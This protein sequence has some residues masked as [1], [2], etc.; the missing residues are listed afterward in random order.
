MDSLTILKLIVSLQCIRNGLAG[1]KF[2]VIE[3]FIY[4]ILKTVKSVKKFECTIQNL[5]NPLHCSI[6]FKSLQ[7]NR[8][9]KTK[10][11]PAAL[12]AVI[13]S[14]AACMIRVVLSVGEIKS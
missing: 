7:S 8:A 12:I 9:G 13:S 3:S 6:K 11:T 14:N 4:S 1:L 10:N 5:L 2:I